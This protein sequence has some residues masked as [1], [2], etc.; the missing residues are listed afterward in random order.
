M[1]SFRLSSEEHRLLQR[2]CAKT[3][4]K[5]ISD[6]ARTAMQRIILAEET[7]SPRSPEEELRDFKVKFH[8][9]SAEVERLS[10]LLKPTP[11]GSR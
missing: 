4:A 11:D 8:V 10:R 7:F 3:G 6:L 9:L 2:A 1:I 5:N